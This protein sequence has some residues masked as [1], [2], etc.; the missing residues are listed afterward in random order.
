MDDVSEQCWARIESLRYRI[1]SICVAAD[2][3]ERASLDA[4]IIELRDIV[5]E[6]LRP[7]NEGASPVN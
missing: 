2:E 3:A 7:R 1:K 5:W 6:A 4:E